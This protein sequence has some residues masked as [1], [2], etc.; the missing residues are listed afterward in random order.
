MKTPLVE[1][2]GRLAL[3]PHP[4]MSPD[5]NG[6]GSTLVSRGEEGATLLKWALVLVL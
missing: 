6:Y 5:M 3:W 4:V 1:C 2:P